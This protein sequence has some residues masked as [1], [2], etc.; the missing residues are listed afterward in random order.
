MQIESS[1][2]N[3]IIQIGSDDL[4]CAVLIS[5]G[6]MHGSK[7]CLYYILAGLDFNPTFFFLP[8]PLISLPISGFFSVLSIL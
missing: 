4:L 1:E 6:N 7:L 8:L 5:D 2:L 3:L